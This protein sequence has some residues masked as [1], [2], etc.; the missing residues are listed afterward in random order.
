MLRLSWT[1]KGLLL[2]AACVCHAPVHAIP[3]AG[4]VISE[5]LYDPPG[6]D[7]G[8]EWVEL[9]NAGG[10]PIDL[11]AWSLG[12]G[13]ADYGSGTLQLSG[14]VAPDS[15]FLVGG[16]PDAGFDLPVDFAPDLQNS[17][18]VA[19]G[20]ALFE[21]PADAI[22][23]GSLPRFAVVYGG[24]NAN[25]LLGADGAPAVVDVGDAPSGSSIALLDD[26]S[27]QV[28]ATPT[29]GSGPLTPAAPVAVPAPAT[30]LLLLLGAGALVAARRAP[31]AG[32]R[33]A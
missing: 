13:G 4:L 20:L 1:M 24:V 32:A 11:A 22:G 12:Y 30:A 23:P 14:V 6:A 17:G 25:A 15:Y 33:P 9:Y 3:V 18:A 8:R 5:V 19:D 16:A 10:V 7:N 2:A 21:L 29:P 27:W 26:G 31:R 28:L